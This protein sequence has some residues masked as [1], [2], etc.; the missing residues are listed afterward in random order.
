MELGRDIMGAVDITVMSTCNTIGNCDC[1]DSNPFQNISAEAPD[2]QRFAG[3]SYNSVRP[4]LGVGWAYF[5]AIGLYYSAI[6]Q[7]DADMNAYNIGFK[8]STCTWTN[9]DGTMYA[10]FDCP[11]GVSFFDQATPGGGPAPAPG[12]FLN[13]AQTG[14]AICPDGSV[15]EF[16]VPAG[17]FSASTQL[18]ADNAAFAFAS[19]QAQLHKICLSNIQ[20]QVCIGTLTE[21]PI[22]ATGSF[23]AQ[24]PASDF[25]ELAAGTL[26][27]GLVFNGGSIQ[28]GVATITG[29]PTTN[30]T[31]QFVISVTDPVGDS[32]QKTY[33]LTACSVT[34]SFPN[35]QSG[36]PYSG[37]VSTTGISNPVHF[38]SS[39]NL[40]SGL[41]LN[42]NT[43]AVTGTPT[44]SGTF[45]F[46]ITAIDGIT[47]FSCGSPFTITLDPVN[48][49]VGLVWTGPA[50]LA[51]GGSGG[52]VNQH[53]FNQNQGTF[54]VTSNG[55]AG[56]FLD[57]FMTGTMTFT[58]P[59]LN[60]NLQ[61]VVAF[62]VVGG[63]AQIVINQ[64]G[65]IILDTGTV[66][67]AGTYNYPFT[68][69]AA[70]GQNIIMNVIN[71]SGDNHNSTTMQ[72]NFASL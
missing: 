20:S 61:L 56:S 12:T 21:I 31:F 58:G 40:P 26:P 38:V 1:L 19:Q 70:T 7:A 62:S 63:G 67:V 34:G 45:D 14:V 13:R 47:G 24:P 52:T 46:E 11:N 32:M 44:V 27:S 25:W 28:G 35:G 17:L 2:T 53:S 48:V 29:T 43:G 18:A 57:S 50:T 69:G 6:S 41:T 49:F 42:P 4:P 5:S 59:A 65:I 64:N 22:T 68:L 60:C 54:Q 3:I 10:Q 23:L 16:S 39:G 51:S 72:V 8:A 36:V 9:P 71:E 30:G 33:T 66:T 15:F 55:G 37:T